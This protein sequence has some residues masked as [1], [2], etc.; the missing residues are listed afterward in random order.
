MKEEPHFIGD[1]ELVP[2]DDTNWRVKHSFTFVTANGGRVRVPADFHT[3]LASVPALER[4][5]SVLMLAAWAISGTLTE[6]VIPLGV[7]GFALCWIAKL[8]RPY[9]KHSVADVL[10]D[11]MYRECPELSKWECDAYYRVAMK[12]KGVRKGQAEV[13]FL[14]VFFG[15][16]YSFWKDRKE[17]AAR[18]EFT[19]EQH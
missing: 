19:H 1:C 8:Y 6:W 7:A 11:Y 12:L 4:I 13:M 15:G 18:K 5:G 3:D 17:L 10:H 14:G 9:G 2:V 16:W